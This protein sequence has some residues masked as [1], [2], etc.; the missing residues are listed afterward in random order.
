M[1]KILNFMFFEI[2]NFGDLLV[3]M[4]YVEKMLQEGDD[5]FFFKIFIFNA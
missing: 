5:A 1:T 4:I 3:W 2:Y